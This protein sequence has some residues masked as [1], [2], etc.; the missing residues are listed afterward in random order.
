MSLG[1]GSLRVEA[2]RAEA[3]DIT[4]TSDYE[5]A[6]GIARAELGA[7]NALIRGRLTVSGDATALIG[8]DGVAADLDDLF[9]PVLARTSF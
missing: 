5:T 3:P 9:A 4:F 2:G 7:S 1:D 6:A 8:P